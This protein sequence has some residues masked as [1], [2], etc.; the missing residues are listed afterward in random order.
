[1]GARKGATTFLIVWLKTVLQP[2]FHAVPANIKL[3]PCRLQ[4]KIMLFMAL[5]GWGVPF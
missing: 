5:P 4:K 3:L 1:M 2:V